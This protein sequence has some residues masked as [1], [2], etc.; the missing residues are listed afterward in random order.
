LKAKL[1]DSK[2]D[3]VAITAAL[4]GAG[5]YGKTTLA[6]AL[7]HDPDIIDAYFDSILW[8]ELGEK[9]GNVIGIVSDLINTLLGSCPTFTTLGAAATA[10]AEALGERRIL[11]VV[12]RCDNNFIVGN[13][14]D[15]FAYPC[16]V[17]F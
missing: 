17:H 6:C 1:L 11:L 8:V 2:A 9:P 4:K 15:N 16:W 13:R 12:D 3:A 14:K 10:F 7:A 5:G